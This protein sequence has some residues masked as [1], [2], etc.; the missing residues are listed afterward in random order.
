MAIDSMSLTDPKPVQARRV[1]GF[2]S[3]VHRQSCCCH[4]GGDERKRKKGGGARSNGAQR[5]SDMGSGSGMVGR[6]GCRL[7]LA[8]RLSEMTGRQLEGFVGSAPY[9]LQLQHRG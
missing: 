7:A 9:I 2:L 6:L 8:G 5:L 1:R 4:C 3:T